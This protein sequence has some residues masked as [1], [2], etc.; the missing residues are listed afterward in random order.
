MMNSCHK[1]R[2][3]LGNAQ[4]TNFNL[5]CLIVNKDKFQNK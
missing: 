1:I 5:K 4:G 2:I 3:T